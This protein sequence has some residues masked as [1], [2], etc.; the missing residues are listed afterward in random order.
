MEDEGEA[1][2]VGGTSRVALDPA[3]ASTIARDRPYMVFVTPE[4]DSALYVTNK[5]PTSFDVRQ[6]GGGRGNLDFSYRIVARPY[7]DRSTRLAIVSQAHSATVAKDTSGDAQS[8]ARLRA[9]H[10]ALLGGKDFARFAKTS[11]H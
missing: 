1:R 5:T 10:H 6:V 2:V 7:G 11:I 4:G 8:F 3:F 9:K